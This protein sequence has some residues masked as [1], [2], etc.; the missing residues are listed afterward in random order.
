[1]ANFKVPQ[2]ASW[3]LRKII[4]VRSIIEDNMNITRKGQSVIRRIYLQLIDNPTR[5]NWKCLMFRNEARPKATFTMWLHLQDRLLIGERLSKWGILVDAGCAFC[6]ERVESRSHLFCECDF[7]RNIWCR[8][9]SWLQRQRYAA[10][11]WDQHL[12]WAIQ[13]GKG[14]SQEAKM[15]KLVYAETIHAIWLERNQRIL[16]KESKEGERLAREIAYICNIRASENIRKLLQLC[17]F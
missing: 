16:E 11:S 6:Q 4:E 17:I 12:K 14:R 2:Q 1:M 3:M 15:F 5:V 9:M 8:V 13:N 7:V 10:K